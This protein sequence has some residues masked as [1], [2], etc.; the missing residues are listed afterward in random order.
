M[1]NKIEWF[2]EVLALEPGSKVFFPLAKLYVEVGEMDHAVTTLRMGLDRHPDF[3]EAR[4][5]L[6]ELLTR[7][8]NAQGAV[9]TCR[10]LANTLR[11]Y[12]AF[13]QRWSQLEQGEDK[14][15]GAALAF[16]AANISGASFDWATVIERGIKS[17]IGEFQ[18]LDYTAKAEKPAPAPSVPP[19]PEAA[20]EAE[21]RVPREM[22]LAPE[23]SAQ[24]GAVQPPSEGF[25]TRTM[26]ELLVSQG[27]LAGASDI[28]RELIAKGEDAGGELAARLD[29]LQDMMKA[30]A[31]QGDGAE[32]DPYNRHPQQELISTLE[33]LA[34]RLE[35]RAG[36]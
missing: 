32:D 31:S 33:K 7:Q 16:A 5:L 19:R 26:A 9:D 21:P 15:F 14:D 35:K 4:L 11:N 3:M 24:E 13:W 20:P 17:L 10:P 1:R 25:K 8:G 2:Q 34:S 22:D 36:A 30:Q 27:D 23:D 28:L 6:I 29:E 12:P 18:G